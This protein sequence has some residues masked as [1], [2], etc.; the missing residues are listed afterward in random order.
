MRITAGA[1]KGRPLSAPQGLNV[2]PTS[3]KVRQAIFNVLEH[4]DFGADFG[5]D[6]ARVID[7]F[8]GTGALG[9]EALS[10]GAA[11]AFLIDNSA[12]SRATLRRNVEVMGLT[13][14][15]KIWRR[16][17]SDLGRNINKPFDLTFLDPPYGQNLLAPALAS[18]HA[19]GWLQP[20]AIV[21]AEAAR[22]TNIPSTDDYQILDERLY[23]ETR[24][25]FLR[26]SDTDNT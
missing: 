12:T 10:R 25:A 16:D 21:V 4:R 20:H 24:V 7:L 13:G 11:Y 8:A 3:D 18:L 1:L 17:A 9:I 15:T 5:L 22:D 23:G 14:K 2:R 19:G 6:D 26:P